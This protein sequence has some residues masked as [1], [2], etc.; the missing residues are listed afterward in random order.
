MDV[1]IANKLYAHFTKLN[2]GVEHITIETILAII[3]AKK[4][5]LKNR[6]IINELL[7][8]IQRIIDI[9]MTK[10]LQ[11]QPTTPSSIYSYTEVFPER[12]R[13]VI[14]TLHHSTNINYH[15]MIDS[16]DRDITTYNVANCFTI[17]LPRVMNDVSKVELLTCIVHNSSSLANVPYLLL[18][19]DE[20]GNNMEGTN[21]YVN[22][23][24]AILTNYELLD[25][26]R[27]YS[28]NS[29]MSKKYP[30]MI[31][32]TRLT[33]K[34]KLPDGTICEFD[35]SVKIATAIQTMLRVTCGKLE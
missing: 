16:K 23:T 29:T 28:I 31:S 21:Q 13:N 9:K 26:Y 18:V 17:E 15:F 35:D 5:D 19:L 4:G 3:H 10:R 25:G 8:E 11:Q 1:R 6:E 12:Q 2:D 33:I 7:E 22:K 27:H 30:T 14:D 20:L 34:L 24:F 32:L